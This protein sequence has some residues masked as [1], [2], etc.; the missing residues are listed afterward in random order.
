[1]A[2][3]ATMGGTTTTRL[4]SDGAT[5]TSSVDQP[6]LPELLDQDLPGLFA[7]TVPPRVY[8]CAS[9]G[10]DVLMR[11]ELAGW[12]G[13]VIDLTGAAGKADFLDR[14]AL[15]LEAP[16]WTGRNWD[17]L[18][19]CLKDLSWLGDTGGYA[20]LIAGW[21]AW[22]RADPEDAATAAD[23]L[24]AAAAHWEGRGTP[25]AVLLG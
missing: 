25:F 16:G 10:P 2:V 20:V 19:D 7:G 24:T 14:C 4:Q 23:V 13:T 17:A 5:M 11:A 6:D 1:V 22:E 15:G 18:A 3:F 8:R 12:T 21:P 9:V